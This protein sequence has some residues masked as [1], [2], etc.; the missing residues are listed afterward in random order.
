MSGPFLTLGFRPFFLAAGLWAV[1][2]MALWIGTL[3]GWPV[4]P[5]WLDALSW[6]AHEMV[7]GYL[8]AALAGFLLT[9]APSWTGQTPLRGR[10]LGGLALLWVIGRCAMLLSGVWPAGLVALLDLAMPLALAFQTGRQIVAGRNWRNLSVLGAV[11]L[12][13]FGDILFHVDQGD[14]QGQGL[15]LGLVGALIVTTVVGGR[16]VPN[17]TRNWL[18]KNHKPQIL[19][20]PAALAMAMNGGFL[21]VLLIWAALPDSPWVGI[22]LIAAGLAHLWRLLRWGGQHT[23]S[24]PL[25]WVLHLSYLFIPLGA[26]GVGFAILVNAPQS[27]AL[28]L[29]TIGGLGLMTLGVMTR[30]TLGHSGGVLSVGA[31][32]AA[33]YL[34][35]ALAALLR[36]ISSFVAATSAF[37]VLAGIAWIIGFAGFVLLFGPRHIGARIVASQ[38]K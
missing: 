15:R 23:L 20:E 19:E 9:A 28:H 26:L 7:F 14:A 4:L 33:L 12:L 34:A 1:V 5:E 11:A 32:T 6:H 31:G 37:Q 8:F 35:V 38:T 17:F 24:E 27:A 36:P 29:W 16:I 18:K 25:I 13:V 3:L 2:A 10:R 30:A 22:L 21:L